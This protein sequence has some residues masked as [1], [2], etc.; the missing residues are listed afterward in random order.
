MPD[1]RLAPAAG[2]H[3]FFKKTSE[4]LD[5]GFLETDG[6]S[7]F[8]DTLFEIAQIRANLDA[9]TERLETPIN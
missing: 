1:R 4:W 2:G 5:S 3:S 7:G 6:D 8:L 9:T